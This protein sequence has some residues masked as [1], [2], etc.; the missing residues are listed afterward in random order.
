V[1][2]ETFET[3]YDDYEVDAEVVYVYKVVPWVEGVQ[4]EPSNTDTGYAA[5]GGEPGT[6]FDLV[7]SDGLYEE[8]VRIE[9]GMEGDYS[10]FDLWRKRDGE[11]YEWGHLAY[12]EDQEY[13]DEAVD[14]GVVYIYK[15]RAILGEQDGE[16]SNTDSGYAGD[17]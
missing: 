6:P 13:N 14:P 7:A 5:G 11:G 17:L 16:W 1:I 2:D 3:H 12:T 4:G 8:Y 15:V 9:W 10:N